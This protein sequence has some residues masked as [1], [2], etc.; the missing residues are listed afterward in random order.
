MEKPPEAFSCKSCGCQTSH[1]NKFHKLCIK[2]NQSR[3]DSKPKSRVTKKPKIY[4]KKPTGE[5][6]MFL[7]IWNERPHICTNP[8][9]KKNLGDEP[10]VHYFS[11]I[12]PKG[13]YPELRLLKTNIRLLCISC[14]RIEDFGGL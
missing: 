4:R 14:H 3:L 7:E 1:G 10:I 11:H 9:C 8:S 13:K 5:R 2:C 12:K 6:E